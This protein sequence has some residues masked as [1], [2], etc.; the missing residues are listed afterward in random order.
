MKK[1]LAVLLAMCV[2]MLTGLY[3]TG[4]S[5]G[6]EPQKAEAPAPAPAKEEAAKEAAPA[7]SAEAEEEDEDKFGC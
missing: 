3:V 7:A 1:K 6:S 5:Q 4:C 2:L